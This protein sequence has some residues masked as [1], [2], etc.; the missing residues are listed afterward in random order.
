MHVPSIFHKSLLESM[1]I[2]LL[3]KHLIH[4]YCEVYFMFKLN[5][6]FFHR[7]LFQIFLYFFFPF[8]SM[9]LFQHVLILASCTLSG[10]PLQDGFSSKLR[11]LSWK[12]FTK[13]LISYKPDLPFQV[14]AI[15]SIQLS[16]RVPCLKTYKGRMT[17]WIG[18]SSK[19]MQQGNCSP[20]QEVREI[21]LKDFYVERQTI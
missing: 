1:I 14:N 18:H 8:K 3:L 13:I 19:L 15:W 11:M 6:L 20:R 9:L 12:T 10:Q 21:R 17:F 4:I 16:A 5:Y 2:F 7:L